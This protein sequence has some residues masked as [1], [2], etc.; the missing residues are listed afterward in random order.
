MKL[1]QNSLTYSVYC[2]LYTP[3]QDLPLGL[4]SYLCLLQLRSIKPWSRSKLG[5]IRVAPR[6][7]M[8]TVVCQH[9]LD[10]VLKFTWAYRLQSLKLILWCLPGTLESLGAQ[11]NLREIEGV[12]SGMHPPN[13]PKAP[14]FFPGLQCKT[15]MGHLDRSSPTWS[16][17]TRKRHLQS[18]PE[19]GHQWS[20]PRTRIVSPCLACVCWVLNASKWCFLPPELVTVCFPRCPLQRRT[21]WKHRS[22]PPFLKR[23]EAPWTCQIENWKNQRLEQTCLALIQV[24]LQAH[25]YFDG[26][27]MSSK[28]PSGNLT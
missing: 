13:H 6:G 12:C 21:A 8:V 25:G 26:F 5:D 4:A 11:R 22:T 27:Q 19:A 3:I 16:N 20:P 17:E 14:A 23:V 28:L 2:T 9:P 18:I 15:L 24:A 10:L 1:G 7:M